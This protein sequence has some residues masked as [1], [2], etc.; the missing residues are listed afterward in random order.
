MAWK[1]KKFGP[2]TGFE[3]FRKAHGYIESKLFQWPE[4]TKSGSRWSSLGPIALI[5]RELEQNPGDFM[6]LPREEKNQKKRSEV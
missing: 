1:V 6:V 2:K 4:R 5:G 3:F